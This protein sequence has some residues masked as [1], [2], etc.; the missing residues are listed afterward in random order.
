[1]DAARRYWNNWTYPTLD[2]AS[3]SSP[4]PSFSESQK[5]SPPNVTLPTY[6]PVRW[7]DLH[8]QDDSRRPPPNFPDGSGPTPYLGPR[9]RLSL[10]WVNRW[11]I[12]CLLVLVKLMISSNSMES[13]LDSARSE[14]LTA[15]GKVEVAGSSLI[16]MP[17]YVS[18]GA[19]A[20]VASG[21]E[22]AVS[23][24]VD[25][26][27]LIIVAVEEI[28]V[29]AIE[30]AT[31]TYTCLITMA[32][33]GVVDNVLNATESIVDFV[34]STA[35]AFNSDLS[36]V[37]DT[38]NSALANVEKGIEAVADLFTDNSTD[39][40]VLSIPKFNISISTSINSKL[41]SLEDDMPTFTDVQN[42]TEYA[43]R[44]PFT[45]LR[46]VVNSSYSEYSFD[47]SILPVPSKESLAICK[48]DSAI[49]DFFDE[50]IALVKKLSKAA[51]IVLIIFALLAI[52]IMG[53]LDLLQWRSLRKRVFTLTRALQRTD[54]NLDPIDSF[55]VASSHFAHYFGLLVTR[56]VQ[57]LK[58]Q[59]A[60]RWLIAYI[61]YPPA[62]VAL[63]LAV[64]S[65]VGAI[66]QSC[67]LAQVEARSPTLVSSFG[68]LTDQVVAVI[69]NKGV[70][71]ANGTNEALASSETDINDDLFGWV[72]DATSSVN[73][74]LNTFVD[75]MTST[76]SDVF[77]GTPLYDPILDVLNCLLLL[78]IQGI[79]SGLTWA[80]DHAHIS[81]PRFNESVIID[82]FASTNMTNST[83]KAVSSSP[84]SSSNKLVSSDVSELAAE[85]TDTVLSALK[86]VEAAYRSGIK[87]EYTFGYSLFALWGLI[88]LVAAVRVAKMKYTDYKQQRQQREDEHRRDMLLTNPNIVLDATNFQHIVV[89]PR[90]TEVRTQHKQRRQS[91]FDVPLPVAKPS[92]SSRERA[93]PRSASSSDCSS[94][95]SRTIY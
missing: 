41:Q 81:L 5:R 83:S 67:I 61:T 69:E 10:A 93:R 57:S 89:H 37:I 38:F 91:H 1:M 32:V 95:K 31:S 46:S 34:N 20:L 58:T 56:P 40:P 14:T 64:A 17:Y 87:L 13:S 59:A 22:T 65:I 78:K 92:A 35:V 63:S 9:D 4:P 71:W 21:V 33:T 94:T 39:F 77:G 86:K 18:S 23:A 90:P 19:N 36:N 51:M 54:K 73:N 15:C 42:A 82:A 68:N 44:Y 8:P 66:I 6:Q 2:E 49:N 25:A 29:F 24:L 85:T 53:Y 72:L 3:P 60:I 55:Q 52:I 45:K 50:L 12:I 26:L 76:L 30:L 75:E 79:E 16:S 28:V 11:T 88:V 7:T 74:T 27:D 70:E 43:I 84:S 47:R 62:L 80:Y 48:D